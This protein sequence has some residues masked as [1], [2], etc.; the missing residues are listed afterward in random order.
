MCDRPDLAGDRDAVQMTP[1]ERRQLLWL[2]A[3]VL[4]IGAVALASVLG[5]LPSFVLEALL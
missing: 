3:L 2:A 4:F 1:R 5:W